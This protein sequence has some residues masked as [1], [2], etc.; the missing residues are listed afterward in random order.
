[1]KASCS[2]IVAALALLLPGAAVGQTTN[3]A[4]ELAPEAAASQWALN[5]SVYG[6]IVPESRDYVNPN[7]TADRGWLHL[8]ARYNYEALETGSLWV[9]YNLDAGE[10]LK[11]HL[12]PMLGGVFGDL[13]GVAPGYNLSLGYKRIE[14]YSQ[15]EYFCDTG[16]ASNNYFYTWSELTWSPW[17]WL[18]AGLAIQ[19]TKAYK[20]ELDIQRGFVVAVS[21]KHADLAAYVFNLGWTDPTVVL[22]LGFNY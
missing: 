21:Y 8:E 15:G 5:A 14:L 16:D 1:M 2:I 7:F 20:S 9:G 3:S 17:D 11:F 6:Y 19:R 13:T 10:K 12:A 22:A 18:R 4:P